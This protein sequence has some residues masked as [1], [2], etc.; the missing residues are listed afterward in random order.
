MR[1]LLTLALSILG[2]TLALAEKPEKEKV[3]KEISSVI[4]APYSGE[5]ETVLKHTH[6]KVVEIAGGEE[7]FRKILESAAATF[8]QAGVTFEI[9]E[10]SEIKGYVATGSLELFYIDVKISMEK[11]GQVINSSTRQ[12]GAKEPDTDTWYYIDVTDNGAAKLK[13]I[14]PDL[15]A[16]FKLPDAAEGE[17]P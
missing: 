15:P 1:L 16:E 9:V 17:Q 3:A 12:V 14:L 8:K 4:R 6:P 5:F 13:Q 10:I 7:G 2:T 11:D